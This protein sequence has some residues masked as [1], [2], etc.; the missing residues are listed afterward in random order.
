[1][2]GTVVESRLD[3]QEI[4]KQLNIKPGMTILKDIYQGDG[5]D[6]QRLAL[7][8]NYE[9]ENTLMVAP[10]AGIGE[11][12]GLLGNAGITRTLITNNNRRNTDYLLE[13][14]Q[15][16][17]DLVITR[18]LRLWKPEPDGFLYA[19]NHYGYRSFETISIGDSH[20]DIHASRA[21]QVTQIYIIS[22]DNTHQPF[23]TDIVYFRDYIHL[24]QIFL[25]LCIIAP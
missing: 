6:E 15:L 23:E 18:E 16:P 21:A 4:R 12:L 2:D 14:Y 5:V 24:K 17:F 7:L 8:E 19:M 11:F 9:K 13:K 22:P 20:Y 25:S 10:I 1:M 3:W